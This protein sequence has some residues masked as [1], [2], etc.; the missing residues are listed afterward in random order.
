MKFLLLLTGAEEAWERAGD[1][2]RAA[3]M[4]E[5]D[6]FQ[7][8]HGERMVG[9]GALEPS[10]Q[11]RTV[12]RRAG[13]QKIIDGPYSEAKEVVGGF[14]VIE[15]DDLDAALAVAQEWPSLPGASGGVEVRRILD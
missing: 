6:E 8:R 5:I 2:E 11:A 15:V 9:G 13:G 1:A 7:R 12:R 4:R 3:L 14:V 10:A